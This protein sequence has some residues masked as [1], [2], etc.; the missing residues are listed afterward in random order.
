MDGLN[1]EKNIGIK[2]VINEKINM[3]G[4]SCLL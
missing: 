4:I 1:S 3:I 2:I